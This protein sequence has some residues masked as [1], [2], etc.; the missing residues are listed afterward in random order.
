MDLGRWRF[1]I[2]RGLTLGWGLVGLCL[3]GCTQLASS[4]PQPT[5]ARGLDPELLPPRQADGLPQGIMNPLQLPPPQPP[6]PMLSP[7]PETS[8][9][10][11]DLSQASEPKALPM[12]LDTVLRLAQDQNGKI[13][14]AR[15]Q[16]REAFAGQDLAAKAWLPDMFLGTSYYR[17]DGGIQDFQGN[18]LNSSFGSLFAGVE[19][20]G[21]LDLR[22]AVFQRIDAERK[23]WQQRGELSKLTSE[24]LL[25]AASTYVDLL[26]ARTGEAVALE[27][28]DKMRGLLA[29][30][31]KLE[32]TF[33][34]LRVEVERI[35]SEVDGQQQV[36]RKL[37]EGTRAAAAKL[38]YLLGL[39]PAA[40]LVPVDRQMATFNLVDDNR[41]SEQLVERALTGGPG[42]K[43]MEGLLALIENANAKA[44]GLG[45][46]MPIIQMNVADGV[47]G[48]GPG[49]SSDW[50]N[51][52]DM[53]LQLRWNLTECATARDRRRIAMSKTQQAH[54]GFQELRSKLTLGVQEAREASLS[55]TDQV[56][57]GKTQI[58]HAL[59][60]YKLS[61]ERFTN[62]IPGS[63]PSE[64][65]M[66]IGTLGRAQL[67]FLNA[68]RDHDKAQLRLFILTGQVDE[69]L[70]CHP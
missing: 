1:L 6:S 65:L 38:I 37:R 27:L 52:F 64:V 45:R 30:T 48:A 12:S 36:R 63:S 17:H 8:P 32:K 33:P 44:G 61:L 50:S 46:F 19:L 4:G 34:Q 53:N 16:L 49:S 67:N 28:Q 51:R 26:A 66:S 54:L 59:V 57:L 40:E 24:N 20:R 22:N 21:Q 15:E 58:E 3:A 25:D 60:A 55:S 41:P 68:I 11:P 10:L 23:V 14:L 18:L 31:Q 47:F 42:I 29:L 62:R 13:G 35:K 39:D 9:P 7:K 5:V 43:E 70:G 56:A 69:A 2:L